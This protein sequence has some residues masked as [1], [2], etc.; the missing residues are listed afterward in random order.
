ML[1]DLNWKQTDWISFETFLRGIDWDFILSQGSTPDE[2]FNLFLD[3]IYFG[4]STFT[5][6]YKRK[7]VNNSL[8]AKKGQG[9]KTSRK[10]QKL[11]VKKAKCWR[12]YKKNKTARNRNKFTLASKRCKVAMALHEKEIEHN[13]LGSRNSGS[14]FRYVNSQMKSKSG[15]GPIKTK[16]SEFTNSNITKANMFNAFFSRCRD[17]G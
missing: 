3:V 7:F 17:S 15:I 8:K 14:F 2:V 12:I 11:F 5:P 13:I 10:I 4:A 16:T 9:R 1:R 6:V